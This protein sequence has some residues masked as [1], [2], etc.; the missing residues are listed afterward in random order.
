MISYSVAICIPLL[1]GGELWNKCISAILDSE[2][3][4]NNILV[5]DSGS[6]DGSDILAVNA[7]FKLI[8]IDRN[9]FDHG[10]TRQMAAEQLKDYQIL[11]YMTQD[12]ILASPQA[13]GSLVSAFGDD[14]IGAAYGRQLPRKEANHIEAHARFFNYP[15]TSNKRTSLDIPKMGIKAA[16]MSNSF[17]AYRT[18]ALFEAGGFP[19]KIIFGE[20]TLVAA[21]ML[22]L[23]WSIVYT[24]DA[25]VYHSHNN[26][27]LKEFKRYFDIGVMHRD[28]SWFIKLFGKPE[29]EGLRFIKSE[30]AY[31][32][33][34]SPWLIPEA[35]IRNFAKYAGYKIGQRAKYLPK[36][37]SRKLSLNERYF[38][39]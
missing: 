8:R 16:F 20:D 10:G 36:T 7:G 3:K 28:Q 24:A 35:F 37:I 31:L 27:I 34:V 14:K 33:K 1:N 9:D 17:A 39:R 11:I 23:G 22:Q 18:K 21:R 2:F 19:D 6:T 13:L 4:P 5:I 30:L 38:E 26:S 25:M 12:S 32:F 29:G 15:D